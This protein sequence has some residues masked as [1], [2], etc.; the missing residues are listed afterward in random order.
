MEE[1]VKTVRFVENAVD[2]K[3]NINYVGGQEATMLA[4]VADRMLGAGVAVEVAESAE[5][6]RQRLVEA[7][8]VV[9]EMKAEV[10]KAE[11]VPEPSEVPVIPVPAPHGLEDLTVAQLK[12][13]AKLENVDVSGLNTKAE[14][15]SA[16]EKQGG[17]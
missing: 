3:T 2:R 14:L 16:F 9:A 6:M 12:E 5:A 13:K 10:A 11:K 4:S 1:Q 7:E 17:K 15:V 8:R